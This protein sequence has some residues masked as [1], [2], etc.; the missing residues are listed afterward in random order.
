[1]PHPICHLEIPTTDFEKSKAFYEA[2]FGW[3]IELLPQVNYALWNAG[4]GVNGGFVKYDRISQDK[5]VTLAYVLVDDVAA[6]CH[7]AESL[8]GKVITPKA[9][10]GE[11]GWYAVFQDSV[12]ATLALW[13][14]VKKQ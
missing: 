2:L 13:E 11:M 4:E 5:E 6:Y 9:P 3:Q 10:V 12:G 1:M 8:G 14:A 7:K